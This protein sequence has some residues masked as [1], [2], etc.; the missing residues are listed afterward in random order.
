MRALEAGE[1]YEHSGISTGFHLCQT[2]VSD[3][4]EIVAD[5]HR[6]ERSLLAPWLKL[7]V[8]ARFILQSQMNRRVLL[9]LL[10]R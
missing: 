7:Q 1:P 10:T 8:A 4:E 5:L 6:V 2:P 3:V 9:A